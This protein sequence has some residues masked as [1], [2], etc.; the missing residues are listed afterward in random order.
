MYCVIMAGGSGT[1]FWPYSRHNRPKQLLKIIGETSM[2]QMTVDRLQKINTVQDIFI[3][4]RQDLADVIKNEISGVAP[5]NII[6]EPS[7]KNTA[8]CIGLSAL[9]IAKLEKDAVMGVF[10]AD[11]LIVGHKRFAKAVTSAKHIARRKNALVTIGLKPTFPS[12]GYGYIQYDQE[13]DSDHLDAY[14]VKVFAE[15][16]HLSLAK[17]FIKSGDFLWNS[18]M[19]IWSVDTFFENM[20]KHMPDLS[21]RLEQI[22]KLVTSGKD[23]K[24]A[25]EKIKP[26]SIDYGM[27]EKAKDVY[28]IKAKFEWSDL[29]SWN[30]VYDNMHK[31]DKGNAI[32]GDG[33]VLDGKNN[34]IQSDNRLTAVVGLDNIV[35]VN[36]KDATLVIPKDH[37]EDVKKLVEHLKREDRKDLL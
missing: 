30:T 20:R 25:W 23:F 3:V 28:L 5:E 1:R 26:E 4:T 31:N 34:F 15:K 19:F 10:P 6:V 13:S 24:E 17:K 18:G 7:G 9:K 2:L 35:V 14:N 27:M 16:P 22:D 11:H 8:P 21:N 33:I 36:T 12:T 32:K 29:G 37:V